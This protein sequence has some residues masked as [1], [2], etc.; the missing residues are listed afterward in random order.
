[1]HGLKIKIELF[2]IKYFSLKWDLAIS[3]SAFSLNLYG[4]SVKT[5]EK[6]TVTTSAFHVETQTA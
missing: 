6:R 5:W 4:C 3:T 1:M 2:L